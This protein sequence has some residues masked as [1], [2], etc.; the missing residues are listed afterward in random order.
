VIDVRPDAVASRLLN[1][2]LDPLLSPTSLTR[3]ADDNASGVAVALEVARELAAREPHLTWRILLTGDEESGLRGARTHVARLSADEWD[4][5]LLAINIDS[6]GASG[7]E[8]TVI[9]DG[10]PELIARARKAARERNLALA[11]DSLSFF[12][13]SDHSAFRETSFFIDFGRGLSFNLPGGFLPQ[14]SWFTGSHGTRT[15]CFAEGRGDWGDFL[16]ALVYLPLGRLHGPRDR[17]AGVDL[18]SLLEVYEIVAA[19]AAS[20]DRDPPAD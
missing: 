18:G 10:D 7:G 14:R 9:D 12:G 19:V 8:R 16:G 6:V 17:L 15:L 5:L 3:G 11:T 2:L 1:N 20:V 13:D 4:R